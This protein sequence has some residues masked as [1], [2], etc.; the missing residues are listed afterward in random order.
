V[1]PLAMLFAFSMMN[2]FGVSGNLMS[3]GA[4][5]FGLIVDGA[6]IIVE[7]IIHSITGN[8]K[9]LG[10]MTQNQMDEEVHL[11]ARQMM[12]SASFGQIIIFIV[13]LPILV[14]VGI[15]GKMFRPM[16]QTVSFAILGAF[17]LSLTYIPMMSALALSKK[18]DHKKNIAVLLDFVFNHTA[19]NID[20][21]DYV[22][23]FKAFDAQYYYR[24]DGNLKLVAIADAFEDQARS[25]R[26]RLK[27]QYGDR[28]DVPDE[29]LFVGFD[30]YQQA[31]GSDVDMVA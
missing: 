1:I 19:E 29:R 11:S 22:F 26:E 20:G 7:S 12:T 15:E 9:Y 27:K 18:T 31:I 4:I 28:V 23:N 16:A 24:T 14:L 2:L 6:V 8:E 3:L 25:S 5:D 10:G 21:R 30:A 17:I 13:Y